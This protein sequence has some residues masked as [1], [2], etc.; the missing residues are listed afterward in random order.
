MPEIWE[1]RYLG[2]ISQN[3]G[4]IPI[5]GG[6]PIAGVHITLDFEDDTHNLRSKYD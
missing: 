5:Y 6:I 4:Y 2:G 3:K 1:D